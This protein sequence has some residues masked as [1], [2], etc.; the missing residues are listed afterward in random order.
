MWVKQ[1][2]FESIPTWHRQAVMNNTKYQ[3][4]QRKSRSPQ[5]PSEKKR[6][7]KVT[8]LTLT[9]KRSLVRPI[10]GNAK[11]GLY[12]QFN[13]GQYSFI[14]IPFS[15]F[16]PAL[17]RYLQSLS[18]FDD[19]DTHVHTSTA[20]LNIWSLSDIHPLYFYFYFPLCLFPS[21]NT[22]QS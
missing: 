10:S 9:P 8:V 2:T 12:G 5:R 16:F 22:I 4:M 17:Y 7:K 11:K 21:E 13:F 20:H 3:W 18:A 19:T 6:Q 1:Q 15:L 14:F